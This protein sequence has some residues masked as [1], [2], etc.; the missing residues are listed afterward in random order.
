[1]SDLAVWASLIEYN[2]CQNRM[3]SY[4]PGMGFKRGVAKAARERGK[5]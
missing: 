5:K 3:T 2:S 1:M 4:L